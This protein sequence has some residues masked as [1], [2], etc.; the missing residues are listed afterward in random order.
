MTTQ[1]QTD[2][3]KVDV[4]LNADNIVS[5]SAQVGSGNPG[6]DLLITPGAG[7]GV[8]DGGG[9]II[10]GGAGGASGVQGTITFSALDSTAPL[11]FNQTGDEDL[12]PSFSA[13]SIVGA[14]NELKEGINPPAQQS[15]YIST[16]DLDY[17]GTTIQDLPGSIDIT[18]G[19][20][21]INFSAVFTTSDPNVPV[22]VF[23][24]DS[25]NTILAN[26]KTFNNDVGSTQRYTI[27]KQ[28]VYVE[29][30]TSNTLKLSYQLD[31]GV[32]TTV[33][34]E[35]T[36]LSVA[37]PDQFPLITATR[38]ETSSFQ[39]AYTTLTDLDYNG[40]SEVDVP[41][42]ISLTAGTYLIGYSL[43]LRTPSV[44]DNVLVFVQDSTNTPIQASR[45]FFTKNTTQIRE[46]ITKVFVFSV[47]GSLDYR[48]TFRKDT[49][50][51]ISPA[52][53][54]Q[55][56]SGVSD[57]DQVPVLWA[58]DLSGLTNVQNTYTTTTDINYSGTTDVDIPGTISPG[59][60]S[61][62][63]GYTLA[64]RAPSVSDNQIVRVRDTSN[65]V[66]PVSQ[67]FL[68][69]S[70]TTNR[71]T[72]SK[73]FF[74]AIS[75]AL[76]LKLSFRLDTSSA[77]SVAVEMT[78]FSTADPDQ[79]PVI[80]AIRIGDVVSNT[81]LA[82]D[83]TPDSYIGE[84]KKLVRVNVAETALEFI[85][86]ATPSN[87]NLILQNSLSQLRIDYGEN[88]IGDIT[89]R[90]A[91]GG[92]IVIQA[93]TY[94]ISSQLTFTG[95]TVLRGSGEGITTFDLSGFSGSGQ[96]LF[97]E[98]ISNVIIEGI[99]FDASSATV[100][101]LFLAQ[102]NVGTTSN[103][104]L[105][106]CEFLGGAG[107][108]Q[109]ARFASGSGIIV[110]DCRFTTN[111]NNGI[112]AFSAD[113]IKIAKCT[114]K[115]ITG[116][117]I[118]FDGANGAMICQNYF[119]TCGAIALGSFVLSTTKITLDSNTITSA[120]SNAI[121]VERGNI[122]L[123][124]N[125]VVSTTTTAITYD[126]FSQEGTLAIVGNTINTASTA[127]DLTFGGTGKTTVSGNTLIGYT[128]NG[129]VVDASDTSQGTITGNTLDGT[130]TSI[131]ITVAGTSKI[132]VHGNTITNFS[133]DS[134]VVSTSGSG[135]VDAKNNTI[136]TIT[137]TPSA[138]TSLSGTVRTDITTFGA[139]VLI[140][141]IGT[142]T[143]FLT[144]FVPGD[145]ITYTSNQQSITRI[146]SNNVLYCQENTTL[147]SNGFSYS[148]ADRIT[149]NPYN[150]EIEIDA[151]SNPASVIV[152][153][154]ETR[155]SGHTLKITKTGTNYVIIRPTNYANAVYRELTNTLTSIELVWNG[156]EWSDTQF[157]PSIVTLLSTASQVITSAT[158]IP[159]VITEAEFSTGGLVVSGDGGNSN[160]ILAHRD[161][162]YQCDASFVFV[163]VVS[164]F[165]ARIGFRV[166]GAGTIFYD[167][168]AFTRDSGSRASSGKIYLTTGDRLEVIIYQDVGV[169]KT[170][171][172]A[173][174]S[175][176]YLGMFA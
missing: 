54:M 101:N 37:D 57:P 39:N 4:E 69:E 140:Q 92:N 13:S 79:V 3:F 148:R 133:T 135:Q 34:I 46:T 55:A 163:D 150:Q 2:G 40:T 82:L 65:N 11:P 154:L 106:R 139:F 7:D 35:M 117:P 173:R 38:L 169:N 157:R 62:I 90:I 146:H 64:L 127:M 172:S 51:G 158:V 118:D 125:L 130:T 44:A 26:S 162:W 53:E 27:S 91:S 110:E 123:S 75:S 5:D 63:V 20:W 103:I 70:A 24:R 16:T 116:N 45:T 112:I 36:P 167:N 97:V 175:V 168:F 32:A 41:G 151:S 59:S 170:L 128:S 86:F 71:R 23:V 113:D 17:A 10:T 49:T 142:S 83:D 171:N 81:F 141:I 50:V 134:V 25:S 61:W 143:T 33:A 144:D 164:T 31:S 156:Q 88:T 102:E 138:P 43:V 119:D 124:N 132:L 131:D 111:T 114:F 72:V 30:S 147:N 155:S 149:I 160:G 9:V 29:G 107:V 96:A 159:L 19:T 47:G 84:A 174:F 161:G 115:D 60:G 22:A 94:A 87:D 21:L 100:V 129:I 78:G 165:Y 14:L 77:T 89:S 93:G 99:T 121:S 166:N 80:W 48:L 8:G 153:D 137:Y 6:T 104:I 122:T 136:D 58:I 73:S 105:R 18:G 52:V 66:I 42:T 76:S 74:L 120:P 95:N 56:L 108:G 98:D 1:F 15:V 109:F 28:F 145:I 67:T 85:G 152:P 176:R 12:A 68:T 126:N